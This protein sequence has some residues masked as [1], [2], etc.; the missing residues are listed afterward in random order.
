MRAARDHR[1][2][3]STTCATYGAPETVPIPE[4]EPTAP[5]NS[6]GSSK[7]MVD[8]MIRD[9]CTAHGLTAASLRYFNVVGATGRSARTTTRR[10]T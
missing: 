3:F 5:V 6:Y 7:L 8:L 9:E 2:A 1:L 10:R 4:D